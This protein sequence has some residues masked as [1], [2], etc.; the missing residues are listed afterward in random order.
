MPS[1]F[2]IRPEALPGVPSPL[3]P[4][5]SSPYASHVPKEAAL[6]PGT[7]AAAGSLPGIPGYLPPSLS[8]VHP[9]LQRPPYS[10]QQ[11]ALL[12]YQRSLA[13]A[14]AAYSQY[15]PSAASAYPYLLHP[16]L[17][18][19]ASSAAAAAASV[20][21]KRPASEMEAAM[22]MNAKRMRLV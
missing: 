22:E 13:A 11:S 1:L 3:F 9:L 10:G 21:M 16:E 8:G 4:P 12:E 2:P 7:A 20:G 15:L 19:A 6:F 18:G 17:G 14:S 5:M